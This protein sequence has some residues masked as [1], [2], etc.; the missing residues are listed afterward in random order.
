M[1]VPLRQVGVMQYHEIANVVG[2]ENPS[3]CGTGLE[4]RG[5]RPP[6]LLEVVDVVGIDTPRPQLRCEGRIHVFI[7]EER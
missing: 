2:H 6:L 4:Q 7:E 5:I 1:S 3:G